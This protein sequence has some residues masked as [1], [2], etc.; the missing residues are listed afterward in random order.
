M[1]D[2]DL[3]S[4][5]PDTSPALTNFVFGAD[6]QSAAAPALWTLA[7]IRT[8]FAKTIAPLLFYPNANEPPASNYATLDTRNGHPVLDFDAA[9]AEAAIFTGILPLAYNGGGLTVEVAYSMTSATSGTCGWT[10]EFER[11]GDS[12]QDT[13]ADSFATAQTITAVTVPG[14]SGHVDVASVNVS[15]GANMDSIAAGEMFRMRI[16]RDVAND[17]ATGDA[18]LHF[19][20]IREQ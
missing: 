12:Q 4:T 10:V 18:E 16:T 13:D 17:D 20:R 5:S 7:L 15:D 19:V 6:D 1:A 14:T 9:T 3:K 11:I 2:H 8:L